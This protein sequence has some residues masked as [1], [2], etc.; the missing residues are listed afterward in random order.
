[1][2]RQICAELRRDQAVKRKKEERR[3]DLDGEGETR[4]G[5][6]KGRRRKARRIIVISDEGDK[7]DE[8]CVMRLTAA[9]QPYSSRLA[10]VKG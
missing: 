5:V 8:E 10:T 3:Q 1:M 9:R 7:E 6:R 4:D 2:L